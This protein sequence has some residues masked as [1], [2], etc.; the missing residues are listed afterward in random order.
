MI[1]AVLFDFGQ[2]LVNSADG[3]IKA[4]RD[5]QLK[6]FS[7]LDHLSWDDFLSTY[8]EIRKQLHAQSIFS[9]TVLWEAVS[10]RFG[11]KPGKDLLSEWEQEYW[12][13]VV[14]NTVMF[15]E[16][17]SVLQAL[18]PRYRLG[19][20]SNTQGQR[21]SAQHR[22]RRFP[23]IAERFDA[24]IIAGE[25]D[26]PPKPDPQPFLRCLKA[27]RVEPREALFVGDDWR[28]DIC[29]SHDVGMRP[30][31]LQHRLVKRTWPAV[32]TAVPIIHDLEPLIEPELLV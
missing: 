31:W 22:L 8:R 16:T 7:Q 28:I 15:P 24:T 27:L 19:I 1:R 5:A 25:G 9:R 13:T 3:F 2:T 4:E 29:G 23:D 14:H 20:V 17:V 12:Q 26:V 10:L 30:V 32:E 21:D 11:L 18:S 6:L